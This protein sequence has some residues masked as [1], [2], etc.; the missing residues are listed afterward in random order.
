M[1]GS[2]RSSTGTG[3]QKT[4]NETAVPT[5]RRW[6]AMNP[7]LVVIDIQKDYFANGRMA[8][9]DPDAATEN[10]TQLLERFRQRGWPIFH[11]QHISTQP[12]TTFFIAGTD[13]IE[14]HPT[15]TP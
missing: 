10:A 4:K 6:I 11:M 3:R 8:L 12:N 1:R 7:A 13:S 5:S 9:E 15:I 14:F 2:H